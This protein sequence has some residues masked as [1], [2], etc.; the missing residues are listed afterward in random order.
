MLICF[1][2]MSELFLAVRLFWWCSSHHFHIFVSPL[3]PPV[4]KTTSVFLYSLL[5]KDFLPPLCHLVQEDLSMVWLQIPCTFF[6]FLPLDFV[7][8]TSKAPSMSF[9]QLSGYSLW[10]HLGWWSFSFG[11]IRSIVQCFGWYA[12]PQGKIIL[13]VICCCFWLHTLVHNRWNVLLVIIYTQSH[14]LIFFK[15]KKATP[16]TSN[17]DD[18]IIESNGA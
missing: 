12:E 3:Q 8:S 16:A 6:S 13:K 10:L 2:V 7:S 14:R 4:P 15:R 9:F 18:I 17:G 5:V 11:S 1:C